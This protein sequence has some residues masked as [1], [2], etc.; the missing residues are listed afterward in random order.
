MATSSGSKLQYG[1]RGKE[2]GKK[3]REVRREE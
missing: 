1:R 3:E 2:G